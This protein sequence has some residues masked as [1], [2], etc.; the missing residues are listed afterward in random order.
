ML[1]WILV[2]G[3]SLA[4]LLV[5][6]RFFTGA[7]EKIGQYF[8]LSPFVIGVFII[9]IGTSLPELVSS[10]V[11][12][13]SGSSTIVA[14]NIMGAN[15]SN[16][17][18]IIGTATILARKDIKLGNKYIYIDLHFMLG[19]A[20]IFVVFAYDGIISLPETVF[21]IIAFVVYSI[22][23]LKS[24]DE[25]DG[26]EVKALTLDPEQKAPSGLTLQFVILLASGVGIYF[27]ADYTVEA[28]NHI[29]EGMGVPKSIIS[30]TA[31]S[32]GTTLPEL[33][34]NITAVKQGKTEMAVGNVLGSFIFN[35]LAI[36]GVASIA[37]KIEVP[38]ILLGFSLPVMLAAAVLFYLLAQDK[39]ISRWE[40]CLL[41]M[42]YIL[43][44][45]KIAGVV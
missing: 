5:A 40:G 27:G 28:I 29:S 9:G 38:P 36:P 32:L 14:G 4:V 31:L 8:N 39:R 45:C 22:Y 1:T 26:Q 24:E 17:L 13:S 37:G 19:A 7:A 10:L 35:C 41:L 44:L 21:G 18:L 6:A 30:L 33:A 2:F 3:V 11:A 23:L 12:V 43:F 34:V 20:F 16:L 25:S 42:I 15:I